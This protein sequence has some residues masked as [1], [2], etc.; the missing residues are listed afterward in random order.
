MVILTPTTQEWRELKN[1]EN[2]T[3]GADDLPSSDSSDDE[4]LLHRTVSAG[5]EE[6]PSSSSS[7]KLWAEKPDRPA[8]YATRSVDFLEKETRHTPDPGSL[9]GTPIRETSEPIF[10]SNIIA[11]SP[12][13]LKSSDTLTGGNG[14]PA[15]SRSK[16]RSLQELDEEE[17]VPELAPSEGGDSSPT[18]DDSPAKFAS[19]GRRDSLRVFRKA[20]QED[21]PRTKSKR[22]LERE[23]LFK[24][25]DEE[26]E[27]VGDDKTT[28]YGIQEIGRGGLGTPVKEAVL[29]ERSLNT[30]ANTRQPSTYIIRTSPT[31]SMS[32]HKSISPT[33]PMRPSPLH[34]SPLNAANGLPTP[35]TPSPA[36]SPG[37]YLVDD[38]PTR[39]VLPAPANTGERIDIMRDYARALTSHHSSLSQD[40]PAALNKDHEAAK[41]GSPPR[42]PR[43][44]RVRDMTRQSLVAGRIV[45]PYLPTPGAA[46]PD[47]PG[48][49][50]QPSSLQ[51]F[52]PFR[53]PNGPKATPG[54]LM[55]HLG[56]LDSTISLAPS[57]GVP[58]ECNTPS[59]ETAGGMGGHGI[60][61]YVILKEAGKGAYGLVMRAKVK[62][63]RGEPIGVSQKLFG[64]WTEC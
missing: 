6:L 32:S 45:Q 3:V 54:G 38:K 33:Q 63:P 11:P 64:R 55:P 2:G 16:R 26:L 47:R 62:G 17:P 15:T 34:A 12:A 48:M 22:E 30:D 25:V 39:P 9:I 56:R 35:T 49:F 14:T 18:P 44:P 46:M 61:D 4:V 23:R 58:S 1:M 13:G 21:V 43:S 53:S 50:R 52:S 60:S 20:G 31:S 28:T 57:T 42:S 8:L 51:S 37:L 29:E 40:P 59:S 19:I 36:E 10:T 5:S 24:M 7:S 41:R 27:D